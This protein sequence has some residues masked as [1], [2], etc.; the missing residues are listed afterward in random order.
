MN[1]LSYLCPNCGQK[2]IPW[3]GRVYD[4]FCESCGCSFFHDRSFSKLELSE[5]TTLFKRIKNN[6]IR[7]GRKYCPKDNNGLVALAGHHG[8]FV[9][10]LACHICGGVLIYPQD[11]EQ[12]VMRLKDKS[13]QNE[14]NNQED[15]LPEKSNISKR[16]KISVVAAGLMTIFTISLSMGVWQND[17][18]STKITKAKTLD[19]C[20]TSQ[21]IGGEKENIFWCQTESPKML[22]IEKIS[23]EGVY[24]GREIEVNENSVHF[25]G[26]DDK[27]CY[28]KVS[29]SASKTE[30]AKMIYVGKK[31]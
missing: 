18:Y 11:L 28:L 23:C 30:N 5:V 2:M 24:L 8:P 16:K 17:T 21:I 22:Q 1:V 4:S 7:A 26:F 10:E 29:D 13:I 9:T 31:N 19:Y 25:I 15:N 20:V 14:I 3:G 6:E 27:V 12:I